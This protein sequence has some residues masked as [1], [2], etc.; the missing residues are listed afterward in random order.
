MTT[1]NLRRHANEILKDADQNSHIII[2]S[3]LWFHIQL[4]CSFKIDYCKKLAR[5]KNFFGYV[6][7]EINNQNFGLELSSL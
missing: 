6:N 1:I 3:C 2:S 7:I 4:L 5:F